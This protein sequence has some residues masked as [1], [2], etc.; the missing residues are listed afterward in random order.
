MANLEQIVS[1]LDSKNEIKQYTLRSLLYLRGT[2]QY[3]VIKELGFQV[4]FKDGVFEDILSRMLARTPVDLD[5]R[6]GSII[7]DTLASA[8]VEF[9][10]AY[11]E[12]ESMRALSYASLSTGKW[13]DMRVSEHGLSR[14]KAT[15]ALRWGFFW[16]D[17]EK[18]EPFLYAP[19]GGTYTIEEVPYTIKENISDGVYSLECSLL[20]EIGN[21]YYGDLLPNIYLEG[22]AVAE[23]GSPITAGE[24]E[25]TDEAFY[26]RFVKWITRPPFGGNR[27]DYEEYFRELDGVGWIK[28]FRADPEKGYVKVIVLGSDTLP[29]SEELISELQT[30]I[31]PFV[32]QGEGIGLAPMAHIVNIYPTKS[33]DIKI[34]GKLKLRDNV[35]LI[36]VEAAIK[37][38]LETYFKSLREEWATYVTPDRPQYVET[39][40]RIA[41]VEATIIDV[42]GIRDIS[43]TS[44]NDQFENILLN[45][46]EVP[47]LG[48]VVLIAQ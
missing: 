23:L 44:I 31:D 36:Q 5:K 29:P 30:K 9:T 34:K 21:K 1:I 14:T 26:N 12:R 43:D 33:I 4:D 47:V 27:S 3:K 8:A 19:L 42:E 18:T 7:Y 17:K 40:I 46:D 39:I 13:L 10:E 45:E 11:N 37:D 28:L 15:K 41:K 48:E 38:K 2:D 22:L 6:Q 35:S 24:E 20:G 25:E 16:A 32:N